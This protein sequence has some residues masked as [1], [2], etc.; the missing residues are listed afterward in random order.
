MSLTRR[1]LL[2]TSLAAPALLATPFGTSIARAEAPQAAKSPLAQRFGVGEI[3]VIALSDGHLALPTDMMLGFEPDAAAQAAD[4][5]YKRHDAA[6]MT[7]AIN[8]Y[9]IRTGDR[10]VAIDCGT[11]AAV[12]PTVGS[13]EASL[14]LAGI[15]PDE[16][17]TI[18]Q[19][20]LHLDHVGG[21]GTLGQNDRFLPN[22]ELV[23]AQAEWDFTHSESV[24]ASAPDLLRGSMDMA[25]ALTAPYAADMRRI[26]MAETE[27]AP[28]L[29]AVPLPGHT[30]GHMGVRVTSGDETLLIWADALHAQAY[31]FTHPDWTLAIDADPGMARAGRARLLD[32]VSADRIRVAGS[33]LDFPSLGYVER[34]GDAYRYIPSG[35][36]HG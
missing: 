2:R 8:G 7:L 11:Q 4:A 27:I 35:A 9:V 16:I 13:W 26:P 30:P 20:H 5:A 19:T 3:E 23:V 12:A 32:A 33:H 36:D 6:L 25:R 14:A 18:F 21:L 29:T 28:G 34:K 22:A 24:Y 17:D 1:S 31:Q 10:V 15:A